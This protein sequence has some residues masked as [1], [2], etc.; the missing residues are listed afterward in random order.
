MDAIKC[1]LLSTVL[2]TS[3][4]VLAKDSK[5]A[6]RKVDPKAPTQSVSIVMPWDTLSKSPDGII[7]RKRKRKDK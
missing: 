7:S 4:M 2:A 3:T 5:N 1:E 6:E